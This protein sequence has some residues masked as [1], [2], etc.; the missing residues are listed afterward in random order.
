M[1]ADRLSAEGLHA[2]QDEKFQEVV[3]HIFAT[4]FYRNKLQTAGIGI[5]D[6]SSLKDLASLPFTTKEELRTTS[7]LERTPYS[8]NQLEY[9]FSSSGT[10]GTP[11]IYFWTKEDTDVL[12]KAAVRTA[13]RIDVNEDDVVLVIAPMGMPIMWYCMV[14]QYHAVDIGVI[15]LGIRP[16]EEV[17]NAIFHLPVSIVITLPIVATRLFEFLASQE[18]SVPTHSRLRQFHFGG[19][20]LSEARRQRI[21]K[22]W[23]VECYNF[24][25]MSEIFGPIAGECRQKQGMHLLADYVYV[26]VLDPDTRQP[27][28]TGESGVAVYTT[29]WKK[30]SPLLRYWSDDFVSIDPEPCPCSRTSP[31]MRF[32][33]R[34]IDMA[35]LNGR[36][37]FA[38]QLEEE[39]LA[40]PVGNEYQ[41]TLLEDSQAELVVEELPGT[42]LPM[43][44]LQQRLS[45]FLGIPIEVKVLAPGVLP[46]DVPKPQ[47]IVDCRLH[48][49]STFPPA[50]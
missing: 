19:D 47:R 3:P 43:S 46:R 50:R 31:R 12:R 21:G 29:L 32:L 5:K 9:L 34:P 27:V 10:S 22:M 15:P 14:Q 48:G 20:F 40:F 45:G 8:A 33:G 41:L 36:R 18:Q 30:G 23:N 16:P 13:E 2:L 37:L 24:F 44:A 11:T 1:N 17:I 28:G 26:E 42:E 4:T 6:V 39:V 25:G 35:V 49:V 38:S 7:Y